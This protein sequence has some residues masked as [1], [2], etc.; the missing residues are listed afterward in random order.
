MSDEDFKQGLVNMKSALLLSAGQKA[1]V[2]IK[3]ID[4]SAEPKHGYLDQNEVKEVEATGK[5]VVTG[6]DETMDTPPTQ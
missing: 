2:Q 5:Y 6:Y 4:G 1:P 3:P